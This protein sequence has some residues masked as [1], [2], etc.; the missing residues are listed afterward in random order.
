MYD[1]KKPG[2][3]GWSLGAGPGGSFSAA[4]PPPLSQRLLYERLFSMSS[5]YEQSQL[6]YT[7]P[8]TCFVSAVAKAIL[9]VVVV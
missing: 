7:L 3:E 2:P 1:V 8:L 9:N 4:S 5:L 6:R